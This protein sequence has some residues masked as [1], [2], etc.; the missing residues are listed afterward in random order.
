MSVIYLLD[1]HT[2][3]GYNTDEDNS[4]VVKG[5]VYGKGE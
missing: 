3:Y 1:A 4:L 2:F 5:T